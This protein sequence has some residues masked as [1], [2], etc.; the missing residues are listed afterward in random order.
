MGIKQERAANYNCDEVGIALNYKIINEAVSRVR[1]CNIS[2]IAMTFDGGAWKED[3]DRD[4]E[5]R[6]EKHEPTGVHE[7]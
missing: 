2:D 6:G 3:I 1:S 5:K 4:F 7:A